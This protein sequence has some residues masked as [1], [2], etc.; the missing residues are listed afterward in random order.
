MLPADG[1]VVIMAFRQVPNP[2]SIF[3]I[4]HK[5]QMDGEATINLVTEAATRTFV[6]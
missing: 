4:R 2:D 6:R 1:E 3:R 5:S